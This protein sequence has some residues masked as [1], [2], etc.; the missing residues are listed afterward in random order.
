M[1]GVK[2]RLKTSMQLRLSLALSGAITLMA[3]IAGG[4]AFFTA[5]EEAHE[6]QDDLLRQVAGLVDQQSNISFPG[7]R[8]HSDRKGDPEDSRV[9]VQRLD[10]QDA[11]GLPSAAPLRLPDNLADG[12]H[13][14]TLDGEEHRVLIYRMVNGQ[15]I[16]VAQET[17]LRDEAARASAIRTVL[18]LIVLMPILL[19]VVGD[20]IRKMFAPI[21]AAAS[22]LDVRSE[23]NLSALD[24]A[25]VPF[26]V[27]PFIE[28]LNKMLSRLEIAISEQQRFVADAAH[29]LRTPLTA[30]SLQAETLAAAPM[31]EEASGRLDVLRQG[32]R[33]SR[34]LME[35]LLSLARAQ[36]GADETSAATPLRKLLCRI[37]EDL[38]PLAEARAI[39]LG[40]VGES[41]LIVCAPEDDLYTLLKNLIDNAIRY[42]PDGA[43]V[44]VL[45]RQVGEAAQITV[46]DNGPGIPEAERGRVFAPF[47]RRLGTRQEGSGLG[48]AIVDAIAKRIGVQIALHGAAH[49]PGLAVVVT[50]PVGAVRP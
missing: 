16:A 4:F 2:A 22:E 36:S 37:L 10:G 43:R 38:L 50:V 40:I 23:N 27:Q 48:L 33:R 30:I 5:F 1:A 35:Q 28:A 39:D 3:L 46:Q 29:E 44:D 9:I 6:W 8:P 13:S 21:H 24:K 41:D 20:L 15:R 11:M 49:G 31:S 25:R 14:L 26:E 12:F 19:V 34:A 47:Y 32:I 42:S 17:E 7:N 45:W 18:P